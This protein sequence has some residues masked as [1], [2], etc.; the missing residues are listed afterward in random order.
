MYDAWMRWLKE[1]PMWMFF[2]GLCL[3]FVF[4]DV[5][6]FHISIRYDTISCGTAAIHWAAHRGHV[7]CIQALLRKGADKNIVDSYAA[8]LDAAS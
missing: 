5:E 8:I 1:V 2:Q 4:V 3:Q 6:S 7:A